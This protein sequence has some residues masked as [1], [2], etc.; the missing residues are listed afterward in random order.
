VDDY[1][2]MVETDPTDIAALL[3][4]RERVL[5][6]IAAAAA[7]AGRDPADVTLVAVSKTVPAERLV[8]AVEAGL[9]TLAENRVQEG[10]AKA[11]LVA[12]ATWHLVGPLQSNKARRALETFSVFQSVDSTELA[13][14]LDRLAA[15]VRP[16]E[17]VPVLL[18]VNVDDDAAKAGFELTALQ[19]E[20]DEI[21]GLRRIDVR[22]LM[23]IGRL[24]D[25][26]EEARPTFR[27]LRELSERLRGPRPRLGA[28][29]SMGMSADFEV[30][31][32]EGAT[33]V[34][35]GRALFGERPHEHSG[36]GDASG[37]GW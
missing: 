2:L 32:E 26:A 35:I 28:E 13:R 25:R 4:A 1:A 14:R 11:P 5:G 8:A 31:V 33:I 19:T 10:E 23:T 36:H 27:A 3:A 6:R 18:Q 34:R 17:P 7:R 22:G 20:L 37:V 12:G 24:T 21:L 30:A 16:R 15:D 9:T 29:L